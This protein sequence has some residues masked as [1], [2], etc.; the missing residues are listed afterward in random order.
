MKNSEFYSILGHFHVRIP[1][2]LFYLNTN[3][4]TMNLKTVLNKLFKFGHY[5]PM[6]YLSVSVLQYDLYFFQIFKINLYPTKN[7]SFKFPF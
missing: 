4:K 1:A 3:V 2:N 5:V 7:I 6:L